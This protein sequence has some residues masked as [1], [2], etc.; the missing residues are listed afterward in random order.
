MLLIE[1][2]RLEAAVRDEE[3][4]T[5][6][7]SFPMSMGRSTWTQLFWYCRF[8]RSQTAL[9]SFRKSDVRQ[10]PLHESKTVWQER[11]CMRA[12]GPFAAAFMLAA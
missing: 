2:E 11:N 1:A 3:F 5:S 7:K 10:K 8:H 9:F 6:G 12:H 4:E